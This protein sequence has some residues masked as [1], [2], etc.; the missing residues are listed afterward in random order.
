MKLFAALLL[1]GVYLFQTPLALAQKEY[2]VDL[3]KLQK[4]IE[5]KPYALNG[6]FEFTPA[7]L[8][9]DQTSTIYDMQL[10][11][12]HVGRAMDQYN[13]RLRLEGSYQRGFARLYAMGDGYLRNDDLGWSGRAH[14][15]Q[16]YLSLKFRPNTAVDVGKRVARWGKGYAWNP[17]AF[18]D[19]PKDMEDPQE[20]LEGFTMLSADFTKSFTGRLKTLSF[21][22]VILPVT[23]D[24]N[25]VLGKPGHINAA[26]KL[27]GLIWD[28]DVDLM[29][30]VGS[31]RSV[32]YGLDFS[33]NLQANS[34]VHAEWA[35]L[36][37]GESRATSSGL[38][39]FRYLTADETTFIAEYYRNGPGL[40]EEEARDLYN[41][42]GRGDFGDRSAQRLLGT[43]NLMRDYL[44]LRATKK[45]PFQILY[46]TPEIS[47]IINL[48]DH[49]F[50]V[51]P[52]F[53]YNPVTNL[54]LRLRF[55]CLVGGANTEYGEKQ[56]NYRLELR[57]RYFFQQP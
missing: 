18:I 38:A 49:S 5:K 13:S 32:R 51:L 28:T 16:G 53:T 31:S 27:Y 4:E 12:R 34:E 33:R 54:Q 19:R 36:T 55:G 50:L 3:S 7:L 57:V 24:L 43:Q 6:F 47:S 35:W 8:L 41:N 25:D 26:G 10:A 14:L 21:T 17:A 29:F 22:P 2:E 37:S 1:F 20:A 30:L 44:Y 9:L 42:L 56:T 40:S 23:K 45:E 52:G 15:F 11:D 39:G 48:S 46:L